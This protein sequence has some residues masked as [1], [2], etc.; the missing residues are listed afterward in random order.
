MKCNKRKETGGQRRHWL[1]PVEFILFLAHRTLYL[2]HV[3]RIDQEAGSHHWSSDLLVPRYFIFQ[4]PELWGINGC[5]SI[6]CICG[7][8]EKQHRTWFGQWDIRRSWFPRK[9]SCSRK[10]SQMLWA[11]N[12]PRLSVSSHFMAKMISNAF[13]LSDW[14][15]RLSLGS[16]WHSSIPNEKRKISICL[17]H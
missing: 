1:W 3:S 11:L 7:T 14:P 5:S 17:T 8:L 13:R 10:N 4:P 16:E 12:S 9:A 15:S 6:P 2:K